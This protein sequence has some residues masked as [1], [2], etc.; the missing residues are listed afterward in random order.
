MNDMISQFFIGLAL[1]MCLG[2]AAY[3]LRKASG[4]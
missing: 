1:G 2:V 4:K 3:L